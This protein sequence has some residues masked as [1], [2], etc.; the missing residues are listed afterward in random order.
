MCLVIVKN[1]PWSELVI[2][3]EKMDTFLGNA[4]R[5]ARPKSVTTVLKSD[6]F[7]G[8]ARLLMLRKSV[9]AALSLVTWQL[10]AQ[11]VATTTSKP[12]KWYRY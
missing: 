7:P 1:H 8:N 4:P 2:I 10:P 11:T 3:V 6:T 5:N 12:P 9:I